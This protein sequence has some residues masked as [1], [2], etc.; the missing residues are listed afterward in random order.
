[1][2]F[3]INDISA[4]YD[5]R[6][7]N[8]DNIDDVMSDAFFDGKSLDEI[9]DDLELEQLIQKY[10]KEFVMIDPTTKEFE[11][12]DEQYEK[13]FKEGIPTEMIP[14]IETIEGLSDKIERSIKTGKNILSEEY[15]WDELRQDADIEY[16]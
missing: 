13:L 8:Y 3:S 12:L 9:S 6:T 1:M 2:P 14:S 7:K 11:A 16:A 4:T 10:F 15:R 5:G